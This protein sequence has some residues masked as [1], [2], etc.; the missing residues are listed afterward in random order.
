MTR[1]TPLLPSDLDEDD[2]RLPSDVGR[3]LPSDQ[4]PPRERPLPSDYS[5]VVLPS[6]L[7]PTNP[8]R[9]H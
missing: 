4:L 6:D 2:F 5:R 9:P 3:W 8:R 1:T 7:I